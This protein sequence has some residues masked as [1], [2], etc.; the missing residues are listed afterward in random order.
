M[1]EAHYLIKLYIYIY[2]YIYI[3]IHAQRTLDV[4]VTM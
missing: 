3:Y 2:V 1:F 4:N